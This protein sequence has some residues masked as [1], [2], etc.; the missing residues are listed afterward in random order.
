[1]F[2]PDNRCYVNQTGER[3][4]PGLARVANGRSPLAFTATVHAL[5][6]Y[7][8]DVTGIGERIASIC[9]RT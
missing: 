9:S 1:M 3:G 4:H 8:S 2:T 5:G 7:R 6:D